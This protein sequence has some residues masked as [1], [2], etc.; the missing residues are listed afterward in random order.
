MDLTEGAM[1][2]G[3]EKKRDQTIALDRA[4]F[5]AVSPCCGV[6]HALVIPRHCLLLPV[7]VLVFLN[8]NFFVTADPFDGAK[9]SNQYREESSAE[10]RL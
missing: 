10:D 5:I 1:P 7:R 9:S 3:Q 6:S 2:T 8:Q 4:R